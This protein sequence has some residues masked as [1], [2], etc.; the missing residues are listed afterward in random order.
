MRTYFFYKKLKNYIKN[1]KKI[2]VKV[3]GND[4]GF[5]CNSIHYIDL[6]SW[7]FDSK[8]KKIV[9]LDTLKKFYK[10]KREG[11]LEFFGKF[12]IVFENKKKMQISCKK[13]NKPGKINHQIITSKDTIL[14]KESDEEISN[15]KKTLRIKAKQKMIF[16]QINYFLKNVLKGQPTG[17]PRL[18]ESAE[19]HRII[20]K[21]INLHFFGT[22]NARKKLNIT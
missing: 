6:Y 15:L 11:Y 22:E 7:I 16:E 12:L 18:E 4:W 14:F 21:A 20:F 3:Y 5:A 1:E 10:S 19:L 17:L 8:I 9:L 2:F 13:L